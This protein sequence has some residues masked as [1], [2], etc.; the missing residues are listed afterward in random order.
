MIFIINNVN[1]YHNKCYISPN[2]FKALRSLTQHKNN[3]IKIFFFRLKH[4][5]KVQI[6]A[7]SL[8]TVTHTFWE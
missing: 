4:A 7:E 5:V 8:L 2:K 1:I 6:I 3:L